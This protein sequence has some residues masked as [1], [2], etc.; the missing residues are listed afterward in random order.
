[1]FVCGYVYKS[2]VEKQDCHNLAV[3]CCIG[4]YV[5]VVEHPSNKLCIHFNH[6][7]ADTNEVKVEHLECSK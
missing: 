4:L 2:K 7:L 6:K 3:D 1:M 5:G